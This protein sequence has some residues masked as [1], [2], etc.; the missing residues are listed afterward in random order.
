MGFKYERHPHVE[1]RKKQG[2]IRTKDQLPEQN[3]FARFNSRLGLKI[4][5]IVGTMLCAYIFFALAA[6]G[7]PSAIKAGPAGLVLWCSSEFL[8]LCLL[9]III[10]GQNIQAKASDK[11][12]EQTY[13]D[14]EAVL[15]EAAQIQSHLADQDAKLAK[16]FAHTVPVINDDVIPDEDN[17]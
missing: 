10:V 4:T 3:A 11:R 1:E 9:P 14:A 16:I 8:Q 13:N 7:L 15:H 2:T 17:Q 5:T 6:Y 12:A